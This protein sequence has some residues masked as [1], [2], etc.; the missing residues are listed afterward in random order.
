MKKHFKYNPET[1]SYEP[2]V[3]TPWQRFSRTML[4]LL[5]S[6]FGGALFFLLFFTLFPSPREKQLIADKNKMKAQYQRIDD[7][8]NQ[9]QLVLTDLQ[10]RDN[11]LYRVIYQA[12]PIPVDL[13]TSA[14][15]HTFYD[16]IADNDSR[17]VVSS[18][19]QHM[20]QIRKQI[21]IQSKSYDE[22]TE[23]VRNNADRLRHI[24]SIQPVLNKDLKYMASGYGVR[25][26]PIYNTRR[27]HSGMDF[28]SPKGTDVYV[29][30]DGTVISAGFN[31]GYGNCIDI[32]HGYGYVTRYAHLSQINV[33]KGQKVTR[34]DIIGHVGSTGKSTGPHLHYEVIFKGE[35]V[36]PANYYFQDLSPEEYDRMV[37]LANNS[38]MMMD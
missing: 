2:V 14:A 23:L 4:Y 29:T 17:A 12:D 36:N 27:F 10:Q 21:Y 33:H 11:N 34:G 7:Q 31:Q 15:A 19:N 6:A 25:I 1:L 35:H 5:S 20:E 30:G 38:G 37:Q 3:Y 26:D 18:V 24:P 9:M 32:D 13:R 28:S 22:I 8:L 16:D